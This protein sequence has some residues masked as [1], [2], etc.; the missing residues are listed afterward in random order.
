MTD[1]FHWLPLA[2]PLTGA[3]VW[4]AFDKECRV[5]LTSSAFVIDGALYFID[6]IPLAPEALAEL[7]E[8]GVPAAV[9][10]T[11]GNHERAAAT[12]ARRFGI[13]IYA[14]REATPEF[15]SPQ[16]QAA[17]QY[18][19]GALLPGGFRAI[20]LSGGPAGESALYHEA[21]G[22][23]LIVGDALI[24][25]STTDFSLLPDKYCLA[26]KELLRSLQMLAALPIE[27]LFLAHGLPITERATARLKALLSQ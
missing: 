19:D 5:D 3:A 26:P 24:N 2:A 1:E 12:F 18:D 15:E 16:A 9:I 25:L 6:P 10:V 8:S 7:S 14:P 27:K 21:A 23:C 13:P 22:G 11:N 20:R 17:T 4:Q